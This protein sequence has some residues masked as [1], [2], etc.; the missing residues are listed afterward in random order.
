MTLQTDRVCQ[1]RE[2]LA[3]EVLIP[4]ECLAEGRIAARERGVIDGDLP[5]R[6]LGG[7]LEIVRGDEVLA[8]K[9]RE[10]RRIGLEGPVT[11]AGEYLSPDVA[12]S[13]K[14]TRRATVPKLE[15]EVVSR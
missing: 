8:E 9:G 11:M 3:D 12:A 2:V 15:E 4:L 7:V 10:R 5:R 13:S 6:R 1:K 14:V